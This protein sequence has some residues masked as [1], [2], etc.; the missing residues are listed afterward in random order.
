MSAPLFKPAFVGAR[1]Q[2]NKATLGL[3]KRVEPYIAWGYPNLKSVKELIYKRGF[4][5]INNNRI[6][7]TDNKIIEEVGMRESAAA[8]GAAVA[9][10]S[11]SSFCEQRC[12][13]ICTLLL[14]SQHLGVEHL[15]PDFVAPTL[16][17]LWPWFG[18][19]MSAEL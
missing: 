8:P 12:Q 5:K 14:G 18:G 17:G 1:A 11:L 3:L 16:L 7:L 4:G 10:R 13:R 9:A 6:P 15:L 2:I 19:V